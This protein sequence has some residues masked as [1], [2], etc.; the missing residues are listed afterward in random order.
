MGRLRTLFVVIVVVVSTLAFACT[1]EGGGSLTGTSAGG[2]APPPAAGGPAGGPA[3]AGGAGSGGAGSGGA[4]SGG[5]GAAG[6]GNAGS[7]ARDAAAPEVPLA[8]PDAGAPA[9]ATNTVAAWQ[10]GCPAG[11]TPAAGLNTGFMSDGKGRQFH[12]LLPAD[13]ST[14]R[15][16]FVALTGTVQLEMDFVRQARL[17]RLTQS[18]WIVVAPVRTGSQEMR[19]CN[20][21]GAMG[22]PLTNFG[23]APTGKPG[24]LSALK[25]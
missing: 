20:T 8:V 5:A 11:F 22:V 23:S 1:D 4:G 9:D 18:G 15:P 19:N 14:P 12:L 3:G 6:M 25:A 17:D 21:D 10:P 13:T 2:T 7:P 24:E 16:V